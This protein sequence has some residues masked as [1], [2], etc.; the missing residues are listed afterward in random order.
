MV[1]RHEVLDQLEGLLIHF[2]VPAPP[3]KRG[4]KGHQTLN[5][6][7]RGVDSEI[8]VC[9]TDVPIHR[10][11]LT[12]F[13]SSPAQFAGKVDWPVIRRAAPR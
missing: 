1:P 13:R 5:Y 8:L 10:D 4:A 11:A 6:T 3:N 12:P 9:R 2:N 7:T